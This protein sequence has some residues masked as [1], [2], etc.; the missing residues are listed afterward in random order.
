M[1]RK[2]RP[3]YETGI[4]LS[5]LAQMPDQ[6]PKLPIGRSG[7]EGD[8]YFLACLPRDALC[9]VVLEPRAGGDKARQCFRE[10]CHEHL[11]HGSRQV[12]AQEHRLAY[13][14]EMP[15]PLGHAP[16]R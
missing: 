9:T 10:I 13:C 12:L 8:G 2:Q 1:A 7:R 14:G 15:V 6:R 5:A 3:K 4:E 11:M 16:E